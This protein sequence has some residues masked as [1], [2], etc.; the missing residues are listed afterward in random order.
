M[1]ILGVYYAL[2]DLVS[3]HAIYLALILPD[4]LQG[5]LHIICKKKR[6]KTKND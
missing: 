3:I 2:H 6:N 1:S 5:V 4:K